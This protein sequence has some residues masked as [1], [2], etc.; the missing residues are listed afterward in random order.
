MER[1]QGFSGVS[2]LLGLLVFVER[3]LLDLV[4]QFFEQTLEGKLADGIGVQ[5]LV[6][7]QFVDQVIDFLI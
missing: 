5:T 4:G 7:P 3:S 2:Q 6:F 1:L